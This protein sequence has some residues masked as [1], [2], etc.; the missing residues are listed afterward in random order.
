M[1]R[2]GGGDQEEA[3]SPV[4]SVENTRR[5][6]AEVKEKQ[7]EENREKVEEI[8]NNIKKTKRSINKEV[9]QIVREK[10]GMKRK[11]VESDDNKEKKGAA[12]KKKFST[13]KGQKKLTS[14]FTK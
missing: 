4:T 1:M 12:K 10:M 13:P 3:G 2:A 6:L 14:F 8:K 7:D 9:D 11:N 5:I